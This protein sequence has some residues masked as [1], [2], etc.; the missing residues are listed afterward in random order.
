MLVQDLKLGALVVRPKESDRDDST[1][2]QPLKSPGG[3]GTSTQPRTHTPAQIQQQPPFVA[4]AHP[5]ILI[6]ESH[7]GQPDRKPAVSSVSAPPVDKYGMI[8]K[9]EVL[10]DENARL[11]AERDHWKAL[12]DFMMERRGLKKEMPANHERRIWDRSR[13]NFGQ[14]KGAK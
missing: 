13:G 5:K 8:G 10:K 7:D 9:L 1:V 11:T 4:T 14:G 3:F 6:K 2:W 12:V